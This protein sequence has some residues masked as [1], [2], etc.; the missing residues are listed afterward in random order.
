[1]PI[2]RAILKKKVFG[3]P[4]PVLAIG[5]GVLGIY[6]YK[7]YAANK[8]AAAPVDPNATSTTATD[9][10]AAT[11]SDYS[12]GAAGGGG[13]YSDPYGGAM[14]PATNVGGLGLQPIVNNIT[15]IV[16]RPRNGRPHRRPML[17]SKTIVNKK[18][19]PPSRRH[20]NKVF[21][22]RPQTNKPVVRRGRV[23]PGGI[24]TRV[25]KR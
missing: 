21:G 7:K 1:M 9:P 12:S 25:G 16:K 22:D 20:P 11:P 24:N 10:N 2:D 3:I 8:A 13:G 15:K 19:A 14:V 5:G 18:F 6:A 17:I 4:V 23:E